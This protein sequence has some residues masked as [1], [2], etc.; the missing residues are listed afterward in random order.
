MKSLLY[1]WIATC[2]LLSLSCDKDDNISFEK[3]NL[4]GTWT[5]VKPTKEAGNKVQ[6]TNDSIFI[7]K[8]SGTNDTSINILRTT[9]KYQNK[10]ITYNFIL[11]NY[12]MF[13]S[14]LTHTRFTG[15]THFGLV[16]Q[17]ADSVAFEY[18]K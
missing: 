1:S 5:V 11:I 2:L 17:K 4:I 7:S 16:S 15:T 12:T 6:F 14:E 18:T 9:Y 8:P 10:T 3:K 13:I